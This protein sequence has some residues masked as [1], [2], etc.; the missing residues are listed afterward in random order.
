MRCC[1]HDVW[2]S[3]AQGIKFQHPGG[4]WGE[5][6]VEGRGECG[7]GAC[8]GET[9]HTWTPRLLVSASGAPSPVSVP[10]PSLSV[11]AAISLQPPYSFVFE[12]WPPCDAQ[13]TWPALWKP[14]PESDVFFASGTSEPAVG[15]YGVLKP[16]VDPTWDLSVEGH[17]VWP[18]WPGRGLEVQLGKLSTDTVTQTRMH[19]RRMTCRNAY[20]GTYKYIYI[21]THI[22][23]YKIYTCRNTHPY[24]IHTHQQTH[25]HTNAYTEND[26]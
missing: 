9:P 25:R 1:T 11:E 10:L 15:M 20:T 22:Y 5:L 23:K 17:A 8:E 7:Q 6:G 13:S 24:K 16:R 18:V 14:E 12:T 2:Q 4:F 3:S 21:H 26:M 19:V